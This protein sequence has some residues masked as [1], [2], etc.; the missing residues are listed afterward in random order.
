MWQY[1]KTFFASLK[2]GLSKLGIL[3]QA[4]LKRSIII[5]SKTSCWP[6]EWTSVDTQLWKDLASLKN[7]FKKYKNLPIN[8]S[9]KKFYNIS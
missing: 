3:F 1:Y 6:M 8:T 5:V 7:I 4:I 2:V 9:K